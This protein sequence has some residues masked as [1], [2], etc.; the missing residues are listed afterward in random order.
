[1][2]P[3]DESAI[4]KRRYEVD[5]LNVVRHPYIGLFDSVHSYSQ[6]SLAMLK[7]NSQY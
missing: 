2:I 6:A 3:N 1:M 5:F 7:S 4:N